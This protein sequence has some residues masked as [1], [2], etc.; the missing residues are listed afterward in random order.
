MKGFFFL[1]TGIIK[2]Q[3]FIN[4]T[5]K[6]KAPKENGILNIKKKSSNTEKSKYNK[7]LIE[8]K[9]SLYIV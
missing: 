8:T 2:D 3:E 9:S 5:E 1:N 4:V 7:F 6:K